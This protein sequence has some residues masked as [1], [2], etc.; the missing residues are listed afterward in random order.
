M[1]IAQ[2]LR[3]TWEKLTPARRLQII[4]GDSLPAVLPRRDLV[5]ARDD[6]ED[7]CV[8]MR[9]PCGC[10][11]TIELLVI[12]EAKPR[13]D[14][15]VDGRGYPTLSPSVWLQKGCRSHFWVR[16]GRVTWCS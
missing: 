1:T 10:G 9:C 6:G 14:I 12:P 5:L 11:R 16:N 15:K 3:R 8:G 13:W 7:W 2:W 4:K